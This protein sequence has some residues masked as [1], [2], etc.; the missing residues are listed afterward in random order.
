VD[1][2]LNAVKQIVMISLKDGVQDS[3]VPVT[4]G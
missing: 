1:A 2:N 4:T 3:A